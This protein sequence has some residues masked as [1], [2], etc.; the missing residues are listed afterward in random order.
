MDS[1][2]YLIVG[3]GIAGTTAAETI[4]EADA[5]ATIAILEDE[6]HVLYSRVAIPR[7][8]KNR[9]QRESLFLRKIDDYKKRGISFYP[10]TRVLKI[11]TE[12]REVVIESKAKAGLP[13][14][15]AGQNFYYK[16]LLVSSGGR[17]RPLP[18]VFRYTGGV[19]VLRMQ[20]LEDA[21][22]IK[23]AIAGAAE[24]TARLD[25]AMQA[26][27]IGEGF[28]ALEFIA[29]FAEHGFKIH[30]VAKGDVW[31][32]SRIGR[33]GGEIFEE[34]FKK[35]GIMVHRKTEPSFFKDGE[36]FLKNGN[37]I[38]ASVVGAGV[39]LSRNMDFLSGL[40]VAPPAGGGIFTDEFL[41][42]SRAGI[43]AAGDVADFFDVVSGRRRTVG[44]WTNSFLQGRTAA[45]NMLGGRNVFKNVSA[46]N[47]TNLDLKLTFV[48]DTDDYDS[49]LEK[50]GQNT[51]LRALFKEN[52][53]KGA[54]LINRFDDKILLSQL[55]ERGADKD[56]LEKTFL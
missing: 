29:V 38:K 49:V 51:L 53:L 24:K 37:K 1:A 52:K 3:G 30:A 21:D 4:R 22:L 36:F 45:L 47:I 13:D 8:L 18:E 25:S 23:E 33:A 16:K 14:G 20:T 10:S 44:N 55:I 31:G 17:P 15:R 40:E 9:A 19:K 46:Y 6:P 34:N 2:D 32:E 28:I 35:H 11:D 54:V 41:E 5:H 7:Y 26:L 27:V 43:F 12:R 56:E 39:G 42:T 48:G 50:A